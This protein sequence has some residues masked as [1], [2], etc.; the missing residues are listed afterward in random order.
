MDIIKRIKKIY[1]NKL[2]KGSFELMLVMVSVLVVSYAW[3]LRTTK[4]E[5]KDLNIKTKASRLLYISLDYGETWDTEL[6]LN[7]SDKFK[8]NNEVTSDGINFYKAASKRDDGLPITF[9]TA[10]SG[11]D[12]LEFDILFKAN[13]L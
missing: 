6:S 11:T 8:F 5:T 3:F 1:N 4:N 7:L 13:G 9:T 10:E 12:Y 2:L